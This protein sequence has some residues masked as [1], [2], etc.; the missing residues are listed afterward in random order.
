MPTHNALTSPPL[1]HVRDFCSVKGSWS[2]RSKMGLVCHC[3]AASESALQAGMH[4][5]IRKLRRK[6]IPFIS[7]RCLHYCGDPAIEFYSL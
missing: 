2:I 4:S 7:S 3:A 6:V 1:Y 5:G